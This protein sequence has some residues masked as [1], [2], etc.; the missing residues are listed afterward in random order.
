MVL[1]KDRKKED[2]FLVTFGQRF[3]CKT[4]HGFHLS[5][6]LLSQR[7]IYDPIKHL[8]WSSLAKIVNGLKLFKLS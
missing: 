8:Q 3:S 5:R 2:G 7:R 4:I 6:N 1:R